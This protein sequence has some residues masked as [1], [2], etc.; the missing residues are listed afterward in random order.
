MMRTFL[1]VGIAVTSVSCGTENQ[2]EEELERLLYH[3]INT[4]QSNS[5]G[6][7]ASPSVTKASRYNN[8]Y[9]T[10]KGTVKIME[11]PSI[12]L[13]Y[14]GDV[15]THLTSMADRLT[16]HSGIKVIS[17]LSGIGGV[18]LSA[19]EKGGTEESYSHSMAR[20]L[21]SVRYA[22][23]HGFKVIVPAVVLIHGESDAMEKNLSYG[24]GISQLQKDYE[25][26]IKELTGQ[27]EP[28]YLLTTA[29]GGTDPKF[30]GFLP[31]I[32]AQIQGATVTN[33]NI[34]YAGSLKGY[35]LLNDMN[36]HTV[37]ANIAIGKMLGD[38]L[39]EI[40]NY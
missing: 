8:L 21:D 24:G 9:V 11:E 31:S 20:L 25:Q 33:P 7:G 22:N 35:A 10:N 38:K 32:E 12:G 4:G 3:I 26:D 1:I 16:E 2:K 14:R 29:P 5:V 34:V 27:E 18:P 37:E 19:I 23:S 15:E 17:A 28:V 40:L 39:A 36:H 30:K 13:E 6:G